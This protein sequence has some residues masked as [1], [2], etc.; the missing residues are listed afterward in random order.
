[1]LPA[2]IPPL[3][4]EQRVL[5]GVEAGALA[6]VVEPSVALGRVGEVG[7]WSV[8]TRGGVVSAGQLSLLFFHI[9][10]ER[11]F[12]G[13][14]FPEGLTYGHERMETIAIPTTMADLTRNAIR[15]AVSRP[16]QMMPTHI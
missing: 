2:E 5:D 3:L 13:G 12:K 10:F 4:L 16:P 9:L 7:Q 8:S 11:G 15:K 14:F 6:E 1:M